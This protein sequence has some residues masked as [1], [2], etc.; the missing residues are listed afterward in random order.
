MQKPLVTIENWAVVQ[1][2][3]SQGYEELQPGRH[4]TGNVF[5]H[6]N[7]TN[8]CFIY[9]SRILRVIGARD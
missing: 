1:S 3:G 6:A 7:H 2:L 8:T 5:R 4:L 9:T